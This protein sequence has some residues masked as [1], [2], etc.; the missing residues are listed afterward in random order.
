M[1]A[2][3]T[4]LPAWVNE[5]FATYRRRLPPQMRLYLREIPSGARRSGD[6][7]RAATEREG[8]ALLDAAAGC[9][10]VIAL[11]ERG[12]VLTSRDLAGELGRWQAEGMRRVAFLAGG[13]DGLAAPC[14][15]RATDRW[16]LSALTLPHGLV[17]V[18]MAEQLYRAWT[19]L[20]GHPY[21]RD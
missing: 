13:P 20:Q 17:R 2:V 4:R 5:G 19:I 16:S 6:D 18:L 14:L 8:R 1:V 10:A 7:V 11:E 3:G 21:H 15:E 12:R 9:E